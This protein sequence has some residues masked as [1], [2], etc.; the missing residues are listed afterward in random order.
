MALSLKLRAFIFI[1]G[2]C[3]GKSFHNLTVEKARKRMQ[4][5]APL[6]RPLPVASVVNRSIPGPAG[7]LPIR[8]YT[9]DGTGRFPL[10]LYCHGGGFVA[11]DLDNVDCLCR[12]LCRGAGCVVASVVYRLAPQ[13]RFPAR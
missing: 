5:M 2:L 6:S 3:Y 7:D 12:C 1:T 13:P 9:P 11:G 4:R 10:L 8:V